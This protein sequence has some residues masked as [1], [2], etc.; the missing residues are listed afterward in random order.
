MILDLR[1]DPEAEKGIPGAV[2]GADAEVALNI[3]QGA[4]AG[5]IVVV[6]DEGG[7]LEEV[8]AEWPRALEYRIV[9]GGLSG[10]ID[11]VITPAEL[12]GNTL[13]ERERVQRQNQISAFFSGAAVQSSS[14]AAPPP[15]M[16]AGGAGKKP[17]AGGC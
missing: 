2:S 16:P 4:P 17:K 9:E 8:P 15:M 6:Y 3:L 7:A 5:T 11:E 13:A 1:A 14:L 10:W 12:W